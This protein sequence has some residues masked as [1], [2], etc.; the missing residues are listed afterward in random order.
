MFVIVTLNLFKEMYMPNSITPLDDDGLEVRFDP[1]YLI[2]QSAALP[3]K[4]N[5]PYLTGFTI[6]TLLVQLAKMIVAAKAPPLFNRTSVPSVMA[7][8][9]F[10]NGQ[11]R[12]VFTS[13][14]SLSQIPL[15]KPLMDE[16][17]Y[18]AKK[19]ARASDEH[20]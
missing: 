6:G 15:G 3:D 1:G 14:K 16:L 2:S 11:F 8:V 19:N 18:R 12:V 5:Q 10:R 20:R 9:T 13:M 4:D 17:G 7:S